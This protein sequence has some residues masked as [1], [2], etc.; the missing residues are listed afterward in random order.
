MFGI[1]LLFSQFFNFKLTFSWLNV[2]E[3]FCGPNLLTENTVKKQTF[4]GF[5][6][7][8]NKKYLLQNLTIIK[9]RAESVF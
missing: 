8:L 9:I 3:V 6:F 7:I 1:I 5:T 2:T 4:K